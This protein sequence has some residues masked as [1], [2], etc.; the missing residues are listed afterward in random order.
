MYDS[1][2]A[3]LVISTSLELV[4]LISQCTGFADTP[5]AIRSVLVGA[6]TALPRVFYVAL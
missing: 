2:S 4:A 6:C 3:I 5:S 1:A